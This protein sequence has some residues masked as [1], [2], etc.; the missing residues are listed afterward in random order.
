MA[1]DNSQTTR[2]FTA[3]CR[4]HH[5][6]RPWLHRL[7]LMNPHPNVRALALA[8]V[9]T[10]GVLDALA[11]GVKVISAVSYKVGGQLTDYEKERCQL[12]LYLPEGVKDFPTLVW[13]HGGGLQNGERDGKNTVA[14]ARS[15]AAS[16]VAVASASYRLSPKVKYPAY[17][18]DAAAAFAWT[19][20]SIS[21]HGGHANAVFIGGHSAGGYLTFMVGLDARHLKAHGLETTAIA[22][23]IPVSGQTMDH[24]TVREERGLGRFTITAGEAAPVFYARKDTPPM[25]VLYADDD[26]PARQAE[27]EY[28]VEILKGAGNTNVTGR[29]I[30][31]RNHGTVAYRIAEEG[32]PAKEAI[33]EFVRS[34]R[35][36]N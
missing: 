1:P 24:Y 7:H 26:L 12:D 16:G 6:G 8:F 33:L 29:L 10:C 22:G 3:F 35:S 36:R 18:E 20:R 21:G 14:L 31:D 25:L 32:D 4:L 9:L 28:L 11:A 30:R 17:L 19:K 34:H 5:G 27:N 2:A 15:L 23:L 13:F